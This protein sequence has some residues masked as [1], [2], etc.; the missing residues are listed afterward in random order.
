MPKIKLKIKKEE[1][2]K[3]LKLKDGKDGR[4]GKDGQTPD[5]VKIASRAAKM[6]IEQVLSQ[7]PEVRISL[8]EGVGLEG[9]ARRHKGN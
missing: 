7:I 8:A 1:L 4:D 9:V 2:L 3:K 5:E 6:A